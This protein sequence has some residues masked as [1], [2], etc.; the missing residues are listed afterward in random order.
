MASLNLVVQSDKAS[1]RFFLPVIHYWQTGQWIAKG[2]GMMRFTGQWQCK[3]VVK[4]TQLVSLTFAEIRRLLPR[5]IIMSAPSGGCAQPC[6]GLRKK[7]LI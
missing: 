6:A 5:P 1:Y 2:G 7:K 3:W 4:S